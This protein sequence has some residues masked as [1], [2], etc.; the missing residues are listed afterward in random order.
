MSRL[1]V[2]IDESGSMFSQKHDVVDG[3]NTMINSQRKLQ[4]QD[5][6]MDFIKFNTGVCHYYSKK[7][8]EMPCIT[9]KDYSPNG[10]TALYDAI[11]SAINRYRN[12]TGVTM[13][14]TTDGMENSSKEYNRETVVKLIDEQKKKKDWNFIYLSED[15]TT[16]QQGYTM[17]FDNTTGS[18]NICVGY[19][20]SGQCLQTGSF[21]M[22]LGERCQQ[23]TKMD[24]GT[25]MKHQK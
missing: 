21:N 8:S 24:Y 18:N 14:I 9:S 13:V 11:G 10:G 25:W 5:I 6:P 16:V 23:K 17:G 20:Q 3:V 19:N 7:L 4:E 1:I 2:L 12:E 15:P 22:Y